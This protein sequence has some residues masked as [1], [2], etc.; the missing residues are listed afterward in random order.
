MG[1][2]HRVHRE[3][4]ERLSPRIAAV[5]RDQSA[6][7]YRSCDHVSGNSRSCGSGGHLHG[8]CA[9]VDCSGR[10]PTG[11]GT[12]LIRM[13]LIVGNWEFETEAPSLLSLAERLR[14]RTA[15]SIEISGTGA[16]STLRVPFLREAMFDWTPGSTGSLSRASPLLTLTCGKTSM[17]RWRNWAGG[18]LN[19]R[20][21][22]DPPKPTA[23][24][25]ARG[26]N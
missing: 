17:P 8:R 15:L 4:R 23:V 12:A 21:V 5:H 20:T 16:E 1:Q 6:S 11:L 25:A 14:A 7:V 26:R 2:S 10:R 19:Y 24:C 3:P 9:G 18:S 13:A 22:G